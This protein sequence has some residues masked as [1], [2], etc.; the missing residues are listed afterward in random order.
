M[1]TIHAMPGTNYAIINGDTSMDNSTQRHL[2]NNL[3]KQL[4][5]TNDLLP[6]PSSSPTAFV[7]TPTEQLPT[8]APSLRNHPICFV[9]DTDSVRF[10]VDLAANR[11]VL[12]DASLITNLQI[13]SATIKGIGGKGVPIAGIG[14]FALPLKADDGTSNTISDLNAV[15]V[16]SSPYN[17]IP[18]Q[19]LISKMKTQGYLITEFAHTD[20]V[21]VL[22]YKPPGLHHRPYRKL[23]IPISPSGL[24]E[25][26]SNDGYTSFMSRAK[27]YCP[28]FAAFAGNAHVIPDDINDD[29]FDTSS[30]STSIGKTREPSPLA[31]DTSSFS[32]STRK[33]KAS[34]PPH[35][36]IRHQT[37]EAPLSILHP[38]IANTRESRSTTIPATDADFAPIRNSP[39]SS[40]FCTN[41]G[42]SVQEDA[43]IAATCRKQLR[44]L[45]IHETL[46]HLGFAT[47]QLLARCGIISKD[48]ATIHPPT[49]PGCAYGKARKRQSRYKGIQN[50][51]K[52]RQGASPG[53][54]VS[55]DQ[56]ISP[57]P[58]FV[59]I[60]RGLPTTKRY[61]GATIFVD[62]YSDF[63]YV[64]LMTEMT[65]AATVAAKEAFERLSASHNV[66]IHHYHCDNGLFDTKAFKSSIAIAHQ[67][68]SFC[69]VN[70]H[71]QNGKAE[72]RIGD[73]TQGTRTSLLHASHRW[74]AAIHVS[75]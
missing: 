15:Y 70:A 10:V 52:I 7:A 33:R 58:G 18:P 5:P 22:Q 12:N 25:F 45:T 8:L 4:T 26:R 37:R 38:S 36:T 28:E 54:V 43:T 68:I 73:V 40:E 24:F 50:R 46:G 34:S 44:L 23:T 47:L 53:A 11:I 2:A 1:P 29:A 17:L 41:I 27:S 61:V 57:T 21:Y 48:L 16:P 51:K 74:P 9:A 75:L 42:T 49:C 35:S 64:H 19:L 3:I 67:T 14:K 59:P 20:K 55:I 65:A 39:L 31:P 30:S 71:H 63:T 6:P 69:G 56:L 60:H 72:R 62:H 32:Y 66:R 13:T